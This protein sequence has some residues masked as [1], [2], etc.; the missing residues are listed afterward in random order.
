MDSIFFNTPTKDFQRLKASYPLFFPETTT[1]AQWIEKQNDTLER[2]LFAETAKAIGDFS[3]Q[4]QQ[5]ERIC[6]YVK[7]YFPHFTP[8]KVVTLISDVDY[9]SRV[10][11][12]DSL[13]LIGVD[14]YLGSKHP[15]YVDLEGYIA[16]E[17]ELKYLPVDVALSFAQAIIPA[18]PRPAADGKRCFGRQPKPHLPSHMPPVFRPAPAAQTFRPAAVGTALALA[19]AS[20]ARTDRQAELMADLVMRQRP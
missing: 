19:D 2:E 14:N 17:Q 16:E 3:E 10:I 9:P 8:P 4:K 6:D 7:Y 13:L 1:D 12:A 18:P 11:Y 20:P 15:F 5:I